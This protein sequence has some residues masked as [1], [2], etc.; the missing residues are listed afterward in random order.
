MACLRPANKIE[1]MDNVDVGVLCCTKIIHYRHISQIYLLSGIK[2][3][4]RSS[5]S[6]KILV[7]YKEISNKWG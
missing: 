5:A 6:K 2:L 3:I 7:L 4:I 1:S